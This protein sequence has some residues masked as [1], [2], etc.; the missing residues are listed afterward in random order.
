[1]QRS[2]RSCI[3]M[4]R[5]VTADD[6]CRDLTGLD[7]PGIAAAEKLREVAGAAF[8]FHLGDLLVDE[9]FVAG[10][11][12]PR[13]K[14]ADRSWEAGA[15]FHVRKLKSIKRARVVNVVD[16]EVGLG[17]TVAELDDL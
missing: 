8:C 3:A 14:H 2:G 13:A 6:Q 11:I 7:L 12:G 17:G 4:Q 1:M 10:E 5:A 9:V 15:L 16:D